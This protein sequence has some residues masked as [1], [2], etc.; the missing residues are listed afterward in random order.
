MKRIADVDL[1]LLRV[2][3][4]VAEAGGYSGAQS[5][6]NVGTSTISLHMSELESRL[7]FQLCVRGRGGFRLTERG[8][9]AYEEARRLFAA[10]DD[11]SSNMSGL[12][13]RLS[14][15]LR[16][17]MVDVLSTH[18]RFP[19]PEAIRR[20]NRLDNDVH[21]EIVVAPRR[22]LERMLLSGSLHAA[23]GPHI[24][25][26]K[27]LE[28]RP[29]FA[30]AHRLHCGAGHVLFGEK[31]KLGREDVIKHAYVLRSYHGDFDRA[32]FP[33]ADPRA[34]AHDMEGML[35]LLMSGHYVG[36]LPDHFSVRWVEAGK[37]RA[38]DAPDFS[39][40][41]QHTL[42]TRK[43]ATQPEALKAFLAALKV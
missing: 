5:I 9:R 8:E 43:G 20:F 3:A 16:I 40:E 7:G 27:G 23:F 32:L 1:R 19:L 13:K 31:R 18:P 38:I 24:Q 26:I 41:S 33:G 37:L 14:G 42:V 22:E 29:L 25:N 11:F 39:Y 4:A 30:E 35:I 34:T 15:R 2:F 6:L 10:L 17:G 36:L 12:Q 28:F 21:V